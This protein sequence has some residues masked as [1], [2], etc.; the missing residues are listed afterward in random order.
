[1]GEEETQAQ[2]VRARRDKGIL[3]AY[4]TW[5]QLQILH[6]SGDTVLVCRRYF[7]CLHEIELC[8]SKVTRVCCI[9]FADLF[10]LEDATRAPDFKLSY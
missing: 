6:P 10:N 9:T 4:G 2:R 1:M 3:A 8:T 7:I 5:M